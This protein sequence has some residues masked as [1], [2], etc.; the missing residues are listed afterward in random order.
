MKKNITDQYMHM[1]SLT[2]IDEGSR[3]QPK[4]S[5]S[6]A[7]RVH[8]AEVIHSCSEDRT[9]LRAQLSYTALQYLHPFSHKPG[10]FNIFI[11]LNMVVN[12]I[13]KAD[14]FIVC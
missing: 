10:E 14:Q 12:R 7:H 2:M 3:P 8:D 4:L 6:L 11:S 13:K 1:G 9:I 5:T